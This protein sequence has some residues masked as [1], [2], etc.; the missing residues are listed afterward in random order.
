[1]EALMTKFTVCIDGG[2]SKTILW[3]LNE[4]KEPVLL[5]RDGK[6]LP[7]VQAPSSNINSVGEQVVRETLQALF[8]GVILKESGARLT[9]ILPH[10]RIVAGMAGVAVPQTKEKV[11]RL[12]MEFG[13]PDKNIEL[14]TDAEIALKLLPGDGIALIAGTGSIALGRKGERVFREGGLGPVL[15][16]EG[17]AHKIGLALIGAIAAEEN[18][19]AT[20][21][22]RVIN[23]DI[24]QLKEAIKAADV[25]ELFHVDEIR[26]LISRLKEIP[27]AEFALLS[28]IVF[29][30]AHKQNGQALRILKEA[31]AALKTLI[32]DLE[33]QAGLN[34]Y[35]LD[36]H[37]GV[38]KGP[39][40]D[41]YV[42][43]IKPKIQAALICNRSHET[44]I[45]AYAKTL[46]D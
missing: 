34:S 8:N 12:F 30:E 37:G 13:I 33:Q 16:D 40:A 22:E 38:F 44:P 19:K 39:Y 17:S 23:P 32:S 29:Q 7:E 4:E 31:A 42:S 36:L 18:R 46:R 3:L 1:M 24:T 25:P 35:E 5:I 2:G 14:M 21:A 10:C 20:D 45:V 6:D 15:G 9:E 43:E 27:P 11:A 26:T 28:P 41:L